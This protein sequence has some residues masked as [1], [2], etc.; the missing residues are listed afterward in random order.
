MS[1]DVRLSVT[2]SPRI[3]SAENQASPGRSRAGRGH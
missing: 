3:E 2:P 1:V